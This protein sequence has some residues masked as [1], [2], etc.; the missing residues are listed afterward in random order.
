MPVG[1][2]CSMERFEQ[3]FRVDGGVVHVRLSGVFPNE[4]LSTQENLFKPLVDACKQANC[5]EVIVDARELQVEF[6]TLAMFRAGVDA[7]SLNEFGLRVALIARKDMLSSF[8]D[9]VTFN[10]AAPV[11]VFMDLES[12]Q[13]WVHERAS[14]EA[15]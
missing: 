5:R 8:F 4:R 12:A 3:Q 6:D 10:R 1:Q 15:A 13:L 14:V 7:A 2:T 9:D 11:R